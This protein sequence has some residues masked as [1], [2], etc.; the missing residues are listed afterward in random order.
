MDDCVFFKYITINVNNDNNDNS[1]NHKE[2]KADY[3]KVTD[4]Q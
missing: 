2:K 3:I 1:N 4:L